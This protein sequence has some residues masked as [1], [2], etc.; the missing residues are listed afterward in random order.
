[1][2]TRVDATRRA[3][4]AILVVLILPCVGVSEDANPRRLLGSVIVAKVVGTVSVTNMADKSTRR[5]KQN[6]A[7]IENYT[8]TEEPTTSV[9]RLNLKNGEVVCNV[10][11]LHTK[12]PGGSSFEVKTPVGAAGIR[13]TTFS[14]RFIPAADG[15]GKGTC[16]LSV[17][18]G[19]VACRILLES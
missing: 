7:I 13:G 11:K 17:T 1:M 19:E 14:V 12:G 15:S 16:A 5:I 3:L 4:W 8:V 10:K 9:T 2:K 6:D 18:E